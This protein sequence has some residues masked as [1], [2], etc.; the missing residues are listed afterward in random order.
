MVGRLV[1]KLVDVSV[2]L[3]AAQLDAWWAAKMVEQT[4]GLMV[5]RTVDLMVDYSV[6]L[7]AATMVAKWAGMM[8]D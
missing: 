6:G 2:D 1:V 3:M 7:M 5:E 4:V 8:V